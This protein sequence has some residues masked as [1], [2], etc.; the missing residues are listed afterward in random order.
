MHKKVA[1]ITFKKLEMKIL[2]LGFKYENTTIYKGLN[3]RYRKR[4]QTS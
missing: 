4:C 3:H 1:K 2:D